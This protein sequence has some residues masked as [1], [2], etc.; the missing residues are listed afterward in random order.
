MM[1][2]FDLEL[3]PDYIARHDQAELYTRAGL[4][5]QPQPPR[6]VKAQYVADI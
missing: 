4:K 3:V 6:R 5:P 1:K 2:E